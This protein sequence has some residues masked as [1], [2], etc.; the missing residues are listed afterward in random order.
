MFPAS[1][2]RSH[3]IPRRAAV[4]AL[5]L[6]I[7]LALAGCA[8][9]NQPAPDEGVRYEDG[10]QMG[11]AAYFHDALS[12]FG[13]WVELSPYGT[14]WLPDGLPPG[15]SP[16]SMGFWTYS[17]YGWTWVDQEPWGW[18]PFHYGR[19]WLDPEYGWVWIPGTEWAPAWVAWRGNDSYVAWAPLPPDVRWSSDAPLHS[20]GS[21]I[22]ALPPTWW[23][24]ARPT[25]LFS[26]NL[27]ERLV[28][29]SDKLTALA[30]AE[31]R[32]RITVRDDK[33]FNEGPNVT[34]IESRLGHSVPRLDVV[35][36]PGSDASHRAGLVAGGTVAF[37][38]PD[39][40]A[41]SPH[42]GIAK[43]GNKP[44]PP[45]AGVAPVGGVFKPHA[46]PSDSTKLETYI[47]AERK[48]LAGAQ[49]RDVILALRPGD[50]DAWADRHAREN[51]AFEEYAARQR[52]AL[53]KGGA[54]KLVPFD[55]KV[56]DAAPAPPDSTK[57]AN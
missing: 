10:G 21:A 36:A 43:P 38:R 8:A 57:A 26:G 11:D 28:P 52:A 50:R 23:N 18:A 13:H 44:R 16:Y 45:Q 53:K 47:A 31:D 41:A 46:A 2:S 14:C 40:V 37:Y 19:W 30:R 5:T 27:R 20:G 12:P 42:R 6:G 25:E 33:P 17:D 56:I 9:L 1:P 54:L 22:D 48:R 55:R 15:W 34:W 7:A 51:A 29:T 24:V 49:T 32:T 39:L 35:D 3:R 4:A